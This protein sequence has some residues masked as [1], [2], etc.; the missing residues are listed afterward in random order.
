M[1]LIPSPFVMQCGAHSEDI[2]TSNWEQLHN[3][4]NNVGLINDAPFEGYDLGDDGC[5]TLIP[6]IINVAQKKGMTLCRHFG[7]D[8][9]LIDL[10]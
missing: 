9:S 10:A 8:Q 6:G 3:N 5:V 4:S 1:H 2:C 7:R